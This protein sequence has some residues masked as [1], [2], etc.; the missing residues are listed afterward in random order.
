MSDL[1]EEADAA[2]LLNSDDTAVDS[3]AQ[4]Q[5]DCRLGIRPAACATEGKIQASC[6][7]SFLT[8]D[9]CQSSS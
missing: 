5:G 4:S 8:F 6:V 1:G 9:A 2:A 7:R 3:N